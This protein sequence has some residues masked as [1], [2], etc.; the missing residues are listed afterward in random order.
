MNIVGNLIRT[1]GDGW[2]EEVPNIIRTD[3]GAW[4][5][6]MPVVES[7]F[8]FVSGSLMEGDKTSAN[9]KMTMQQRVI[10]SGL[11]SIKGRD[12]AKIVRLFKAMAVFM[13]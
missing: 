11:D 6:L 5:E 7:Q 10:Q 8:W 12:A 13:V 2:E 1:F 9:G 4:S 3:M